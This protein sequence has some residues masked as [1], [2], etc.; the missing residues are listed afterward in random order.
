VV[1]TLGILLLA[2][3]DSQAQEILS[4][5]SGSVSNALVSGVNAEHQNIYDDLT[6]S[7]GYNWTEDISTSLGLGLVKSFTQEAKTLMKDMIIGIAHRNLYTHADT[8]IR[9]RGFSRLFLPTST[10]SRNRSQVLALKTGLG[11]SKDIDSF[12]LGYELAGSYFA[13]RFRTAKNGSSNKHYGMTNTVT[14]GYQFSAPLSFNTVWSLLNFK[15]YNETPKTTFSFIQELSYSVS[16]RMNLTGGL[17][18]GGRQYRNNG[19]ELNLS[20]FDV[21]GT[22][23]FLGVDL[24]I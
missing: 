6:A 15:T 17:S 21:E 14:V 22:E 9:L 24:S 2:G 7:L 20:L 16:P 23:I 13:N 11:L 4:N 10:E 8:D 12:M 1:W 18:T 5:V 3:T 19:E